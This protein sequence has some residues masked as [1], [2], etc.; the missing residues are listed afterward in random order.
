[1]SYILLTNDAERKEY[2][3]QIEARLAQLEKMSKKSSKTIWVTQ[4][5][6]AIQATKEELEAA[7]K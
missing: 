2:I 6:D 5:E 4:W 7:K 3:K 1:M